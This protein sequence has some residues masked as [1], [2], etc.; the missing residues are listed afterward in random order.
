[1]LENKVK[2]YALIRDGYVYNAW[3]AKTLEE[4]QEDNPKDLVVEVTI[5]NSPWAFGEKYIERK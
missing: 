5:E 4:A 1:M 3:F 2:L